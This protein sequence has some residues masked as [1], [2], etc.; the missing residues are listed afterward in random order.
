MEAALR[1]A[2]S[3]IR[4]QLKLGVRS[5]HTLTD[6]RE[7]PSRDEPFYSVVFA[8]MRRPPVWTWP[9]FSA[10]VDALTRLTE[11]PGTPV[12]V[13][14]VQSDESGEKQARF[15]RLS[16]SPE[17]HRRWVQGAPDTDRI[18]ETREFCFT[19]IWAPGWSHCEKEDGAPYVFI[20]LDNPFVAGHPRDGQFNQLVH[21]A[22]PVA[23]A[24]HHAS[25]VL[26]ALTD[27]GAG[28]D[29]VLSVYRITPWWHQLESVQDAL[30]NHFHYVGLDE[31]S[32]P[33]LKQLRV[34]WLPFTGTFG[35]P[36]T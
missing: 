19:E 22:L 1:A 33:D 18:P 29:S 17:S 24:E 27:I 20:A 7:I 26:S 21:V 15:G 9:T 31:D 4:S 6:V 32:I 25:S 2:F 5:L 36:A 8:G 10:V 13:R 16:W 28:I 23:L 14:S 11:L 30:T 34:A 3:C 35:A 12:A